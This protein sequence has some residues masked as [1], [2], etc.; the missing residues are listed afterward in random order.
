[1]KNHE[2]QST[3]DKTGSTEGGG[4]QFRFVLIIIAVGV[5]GLIAKAM[6]LF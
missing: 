3:V 6:G 2:Q 4:W 5:L 1:M